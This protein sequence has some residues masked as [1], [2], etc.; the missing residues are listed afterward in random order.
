ME[1]CSPWALPRDRRE[2]PGRGQARGALVQE[3]GR[4]ACDDGQAH[5][6]NEAKSSQRGR[7]DLPQ[8]IEK[9]IHDTPSCRAVPTGGLEIDAGFVRRV[10][11]RLPAS[12][13]EA[14]VPGCP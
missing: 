2:T 6:A 12:G 9:I 14:D 4:G 13:R 3:A 7:A 1:P 5:N 10:E 11:L 8:D